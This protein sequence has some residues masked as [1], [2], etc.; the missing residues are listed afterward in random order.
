MCKTSDRTSSSD[1]V[2]LTAN[3]RMPC[4]ATP[5]GTLFSHTL[6]T[7]RLSSLKFADAVVDDFY[8]IIRKNGTSLVCSEGAVIRS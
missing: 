4:F 8:A 5:A 3:H 2:H 1:I 7:S 6:S